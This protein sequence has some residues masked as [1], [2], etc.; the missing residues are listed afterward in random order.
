MKILNLP[1]LGLLFPYLF[2]ENTILVPT[3]WG[4]SQFGPYYFQLVVNLV[5]T[6]NSL[7][8]NAYVA[9]GLPCWH[10]CG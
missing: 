7:M 1:L 9:N 5:L 3:F 10:T 6:V 4:Y 2:G 8:E